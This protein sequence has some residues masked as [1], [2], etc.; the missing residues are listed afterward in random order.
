MTLFT[1]AWQRY[2][3]QPTI[4]WRMTIVWGITKQSVISTNAYSVTI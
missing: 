1:E 2:W 4:I 3:R